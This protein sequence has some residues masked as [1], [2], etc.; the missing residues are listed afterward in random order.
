[1]SKFSSGKYTVKFP[2]KYVG[3]NIGNITYRSS[4]EF[5]VMTE[6]DS[7]SPNIL[8]WSS[9]S[10]PIKYLNP[11]TQKWCNYIPD[12]FIAYIDANAKKHV[13]IM[14]VKP[15]KESPILNAN[16]LWESRGGSK[17][18]KL[19][20]IINA[21]K[22]QAAMI[23]CGKRGWKFRICTEQQLFAFKRK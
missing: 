5:A 10:V 15:N 8:G 4:W 12:F 13:E 11:L 16:G 1:M 14:E 6:F 17:K 22:W 20:Q 21:A 19:V 7:G 2:N 23:Y 3:T 9:E 18:D